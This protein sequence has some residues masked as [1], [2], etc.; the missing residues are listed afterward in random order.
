MLDKLSR[1]SYYYFL[2]EYSVYNQIVITLKDQVK[3]TFTC[4]YG[5]YAFKRISFKLCN[6][7]ATFQRCM[8]TIFANLIK[9]IMEVFMDNFSVFGCSFDNCLDNLGVV[10]QRYREKNLVLN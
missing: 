5:N 10:L 7:P 2:D 4:P 8:M 6:A 3:T 9:N 1:H